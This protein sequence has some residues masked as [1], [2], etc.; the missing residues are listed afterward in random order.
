VSECV[1]VCVGVCVDVSVCVRACVC[2]RAC[3]CVSER[4]SVCMRVCGST[5]SLT[6]NDEYNLSSSATSAHA[7][8]C[9][10]SSAACAPLLQNSQKSAHDRIHRPTA[11]YVWRSDF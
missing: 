9:A 4:E 11:E 7:T 10:I 6:P 8:A 5:C 1:G 2:A 3:V